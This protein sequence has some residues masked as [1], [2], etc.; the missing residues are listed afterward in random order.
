MAFLSG[1]VLV[2][3]AAA[4][5]A[6]FA[7]LH[8]PANGQWHS[9]AG[10]WSHRP[11]G[12]WSHHLH[13]NWSHRPHGN[14]TG[15]LQWMAGGRPNRPFNLRPRF[16]LNSFPAQALQAFKEPPPSEPQEAFPDQSAQSPP[17]APPSAFSPST[18]SQQPADSLMSIMPFPM[19]FM[20]PGLFPFPEKNNESE[21][22]PPPEMPSEMF[23][24]FAP[25]GQS[26][27]RFPGALPA[28]NEQAFQT[29]V[30]PA[31]PERPARNTGIVPPGFPFPSAQ[32]PMAAAVR[33]PFFHHGASHRIKL[34]SR[35]PTN[36][37]QQ[38][39]GQNSLSVVHLG[40]R[41]RPSSS[42]APSS[43]TGQGSLAVVHLH[44]RPAQQLA[45]DQPP[46]P[47]QENDAQ[48]PSI[49]LPARQTG[50][51][52]P[53]NPPSAPQLSVVH[54]NPRQGSA[55]SPPAAQPGKLVLVKLPSRLTATQSTAGQDPP[56][57][58][59]ADADQGQLPVVAL[60]PR[61]QAP[62]QNDAPPQEP[63]SAPADAPTSAG[64]QDSPQ[65]PIV[66]LGARQHGDLG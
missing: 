30:M 34:P 51:I 53:P 40:P 33:P 19:P 52:P 45:Q 55:S 49:K 31:E 26:D 29:D 21:A 11:H 20:P 48:P 1:F 62:A 60:R 56:P 32:S 27:F 17:F 63:V 14:W 3:M 36:E 38:P 9:L 4:A 7:G 66:H 44:A 46:A 24:M 39:E 42:L 58:A 64:G 16:G 43:P 41:D 61:P 15:R 12:N 47:Q 37:A 35:A 50:P 6:H 22:V 65:L 28:G 2:L 23:T 25:F 5:T 57:S 10:N 13:G 54:L 8:R 18:D 59:P